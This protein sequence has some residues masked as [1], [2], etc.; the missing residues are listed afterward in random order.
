MPNYVLNFQIQGS[1]H[2]TTRLCCKLWIRRFTISIMSVRGWDG[3]E[4]KQFLCTVRSKYTTAQDMQTCI[5]PI[6]L[7]H[8]IMHLYSYRL[9]WRRFNRHFLRKQPNESERCI[10]ALCRQ[11][12]LLTTKFEH[13]CRNDVYNHCYIVWLCLR[14]IPW[15]IKYVLVFPTW[16]LGMDSVEACDRD[17]KCSRPNGT[18]HSVLE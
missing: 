13:R 11:V 1:D 3:G 10:V 16:E 15:V 5:Q 18:M 17:M 14:K 2:Y 12:F 6:K 8:F 4:G 9:H 7:L